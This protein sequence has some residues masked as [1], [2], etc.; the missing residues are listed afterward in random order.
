MAEK[1]SEDRRAYWLK[2]ERFWL[3]QIEPDKAAAVDVVKV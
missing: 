2:M 3:S 1:A